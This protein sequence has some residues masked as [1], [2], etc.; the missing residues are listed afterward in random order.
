[1]P[2]ERQAALDILKT[3]P[4]QTL[5]FSTLAQQLVKTHALGFGVDPEDVVYSLRSTGEVEYDPRTEIVTLKP[6]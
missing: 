3:M 1:M 5:D 2:S 6:K 4:G